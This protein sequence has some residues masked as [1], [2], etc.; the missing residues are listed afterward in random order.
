M[1]GPVDEGFNKE[2]DKLRLN[3]LDSPGLDSPSPPAGI[4]FIRNSLLLKN[5]GMT[6]T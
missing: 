3:Q 6:V 4:Q 5:A 2:K 1:S